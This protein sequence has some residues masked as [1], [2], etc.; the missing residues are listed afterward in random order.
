[1]TREYIMQ[2]TVDSDGHEHGLTRKEE[3]VRCK[4]CK[5]RIWSEDD[6]DYICKV[7]AFLVDEGYFCGEGKRKQ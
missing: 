7:D 2:V 1:M 3:L 4:D 6:Y 5:N